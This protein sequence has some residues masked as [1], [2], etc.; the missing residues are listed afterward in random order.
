MNACRGHNCAKPAPTTNRTPNGCYCDEHFARWT[1]GRAR[2][3]LA[4]PSSG[5]PIWQ[6]PQLALMARE[7]EAM[8]AARWARMQAEFSHSVSRW[9]RSAPAR[10]R[11]AAGT[12]MGGWST[13]RSAG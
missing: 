2:R 1:A 9:N 6:S 7:A 8:T 11:A 5:D 13:L 3:L 12:G 4:L 10:K